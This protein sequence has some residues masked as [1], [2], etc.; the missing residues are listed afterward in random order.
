[1]LMGGDHQ[2]DCPQRNINKIQSENI[3]RI[4][5]TITSTD[6]VRDRLEQL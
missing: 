3:A 5:G 2:D 6:C 1:M 4:G